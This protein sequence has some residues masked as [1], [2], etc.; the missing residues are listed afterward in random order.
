MP[1]ILQC[2]NTIFL[3]LLGPIVDNFQSTIV[4][5]TERD[6]AP[7]NSAIDESPAKS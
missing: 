6:L 1:C 2:A 4:H 5:H 3:C 7:T